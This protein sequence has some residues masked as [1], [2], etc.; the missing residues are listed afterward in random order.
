MS[1]GKSEHDAKEIEL[2]LEFDPADVSAIL[3]HPL[4]VQE[5]AE[6]R[7]L[8][9]VYYDT[10]DDALRKKGVFLRVRANGEGYLQTIKTAHD[11]AEF[12]ERDEWEC[13]LP[14]HVPDLDAA[15]GTALEPLLTPEVCAALQPRF[16]TRIQRK[17]Y[18]IDHEGTEVELVVDRGEVTADVRAAPICEVELELKSGDRRALFVLAKALAEDLR[19]TLGIKTKAERGFELL[20]DRDRAVQEAGP[21][22]VTPDM[23]CG[24][25]FRVI[26]RNCLR[27]V[28]VNRP[29]MLEGRAEALH[30]MRVGLRRMRAAITLFGNMVAGAQCESIKAALKWIG[31]ELGPARDLD[32]FA[33]DVLEPLRAANPD[34]PSLAVIQRDFVGRRADAYARAIEAVGSSRFRGTLLDLAAWIE[35]G[36]WDREG[37]A[38]A[39]R[40]VTTFAAG[41]LARM[42]RAI[43]KNGK[44]LRKLSVAERHRLRIR[45]K[46]LRYATEFFAKSFAGGKSAKRRK[47]SL[48][49]LERLQDALG[50]LN[51]IATRQTLLAPDTEDARLAH[52]NG[53]L[54][55]DNNEKK[56]LK[57]A[58]RA[59]ERFADAKAFWKA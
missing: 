22:R 47:T 46:R 25:A 39:E 19:L 33:A 20:D 55:Q 43:K 5:T 31:G 59:Y 10:I 18:L 35:I 32:V 40:P 37:N 56:W 3:A 6:T 23:T 27:Q 16:H 36:D 53:D 52:T 29:A 7:E 8:I 50:A 54:A 42:R 1:A 30:Q 38:V 15:S 49:A 57:K 34:D 2:K 24:E 14:S 51:D 45:A 28:L 58:E 4:L 13:S 44:A 12:L 41:K 26:A 21:V 9:S 17:K 11:E 48:V